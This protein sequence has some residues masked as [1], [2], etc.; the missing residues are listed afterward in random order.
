MEDYLTDPSA[1]ELTPT[2]TSSPSALRQL[3]PWAVAGLM[4]TAF[5]I[6]L[7]VLWPTPPPSQPLTRMAM[8]LPS[9]QRLTNAGRHQV[10]FS[11]D[12]T[13]LAYAANNQL[14][15]PAMDQLEATP[16]RGT[17]EGN[18]RSPFFSPDGEWVRF[19][20]GELKKVAI[21]GGA[22]VTLC[23]A[24]SPWGAS[25]G[26]DGRIVFG[27]RQ[28]GIWQV[29]ANGGEK[30]L[31][32]SM[33]SEKGE[34][35]H[36]PQILP[37]G[38]AVL[39]TLGSTGGS[40]DDAQIVVQGL[41]TGERKVLING[42][43]DARYVPTGHLVYVQEGILLAVPFDVARLEVTGGRVPVVENVMQGIAATRS[44]GAAQFSFSGLGSLVY[45]SGRAV[46]IGSSLVWVDRRGNSQPVTDILNQYVGPQLSPDGER[47]ALLIGSLAAGDI[48]TYYLGRDALTKFTLGGHSA[49][50]RWT[51]DGKKVTYASTR[52][53]KRNIY[54]MATDGGGAEEPLTSGPHFQYPNSFSPDGKFLAFVEA[55]PETGNDIYI[56]PME[57][58]GQPYAFV[59]TTANEEGA[60]FSRDG[61]WLAYVSNESGQDE[62]Y[63]KPF[64]GPG[65]RWPISSGG[66]VQPLWS[67][68][69]SELFYYNAG[70]ITSYGRKLGMRV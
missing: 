29:S 12:G 42:G 7:V 52:E 4:T 40:W 1:Y 65:G 43:T 22:P 61:Q 31:L 45:V 20:A 41:E 19:W 59:N 44:T 60:Q 54:A 68:D 69:G 25:W 55:R 49:F 50:P 46:R 18:G 14:Y 37:G 58:D 32:I 2:S 57:G 62:V 17:A 33:D 30:E 9:G 3:V 53:G 66:G 27:Q 11:P 36:G 64:P 23:E 10:A 6:G 70:K 63:V 21:T 67:P 47:I 34:Q 15:L 26:A 24:A 56:L 8:V 35:A 5:L 38:E 13:H 48:W 51:P 39:F 28:E 16:I